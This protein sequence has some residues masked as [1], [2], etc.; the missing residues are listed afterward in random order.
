MV[1]WKHKGEY[2]YM[3]PNRTYTQEEKHEL[4][5]LG[6]MDKIFEYDSKHGIPH[7]SKLVEEYERLKE[8]YKEYIQ[9]I[10]HLL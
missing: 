6:D 1:S 5:Y 2:K 8:K 10:S 9:E 7:D 3:V 4:E